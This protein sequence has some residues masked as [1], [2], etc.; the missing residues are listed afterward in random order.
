MTI[1]PWAVVPKSCALLV[2]D[3]QNDFVRDGFP[4]AVP[5]ARDRLPVMRN[6]VDTCRAAGV[7]VSYTQH[8][9]YD[10]FDVSPRETTY[11]PRLQ[12]TGMRDGTH[13]AEIVEELAPQPREMVVRKHRCDGRLTAGSR[14]LDQR[15][16]RLVEVEQ[17]G[18]VDVAVEPGRKLPQ[19]SD[20]GRREDD[21]TATLVGDAVRFIDLPDPVSP[22]DVGPEDRG[23]IGPRIGS[24]RF[25]GAPTTFRI[26]GHACLLSAMRRVKAWR[27]GTE[28]PGTAHRRRTTPGS[29]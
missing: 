2:I 4:M 7:P 19:V 16:S 3:M 17:S 24:G 25:R 15:I 21:D 29:R 18:G 26:V 6:T 28:G 8:I 23:G 10:T 5:M 1:P 27:T 13:G 20:G 12:Q 14:A 22:L 9:L 11:L